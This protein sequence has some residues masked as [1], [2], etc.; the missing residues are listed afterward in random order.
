MPTALAAPVLLGAGI[1]AYVALPQEPSL[2]SIVAMSLAF[3]AACLVAL[4]SK[5]WRLAALALLAYGLIIYLDLRYHAGQ[6]D[7][8]LEMFQWLMLAAALAWFSFM[9]GYVSALRARTNKSEAFYRTMW[10]TAQDAVLIVDAGGRIEYANPAV[11][12]VFGEAPAALRGK[13]L[14]PLVPARLREGRGSTFRDYLDSCRLPAVPQPNFLALRF[15]GQRPQRRQHAQLMQH[16]H[17]VG[18]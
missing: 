13:A 5:R 11:Q 16:A 7:A 12:A 14:L 18:A 9:G 4:G 3:L 17:A 15:A 1:G 6:F 2:A 10:E 8:R